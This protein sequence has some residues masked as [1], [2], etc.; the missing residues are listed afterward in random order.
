[1]GNS[2]LLEFK[3]RQLQVEH[4]MHQVWSP[5]PG[6][7]PVSYALFYAFIQY[8]FLQCGRKFGKTEFE[9][10]CMYMWAQLFPGS[11]IYYIADTMKHAGELVWQNGRL[12]RFFLTLKQMQDES[13][14]DYR[15][16][17]LIGQTLHTSWIE[18]ANNSEMRVWFRNGSFIKCDGAEN[19]ANADGIEPSMMVY[20]EYKHHDPRFHEAME[21]NLKVKKA[22][23]LIVGT[24]PE[25]FENNYCK[26]AKSFQMQ[27]NGLFIKR[28][29][30]MN[31]IM[32]PKGEDDPEFIDEKEKYEMRGDWDV[33]QRE[34]MAE[35]VLGGSSSIFPMF[36]PARRND[37]TDEIEK[38]SKHVIHRAEILAQIKRYPKDW[39]YHI[40]FDAGTTTC[41]AVLVGCINVHTKKVLILDEIYETNQNQTSAKQIW[42]RAKALMEKYWPVEDEWNMV[43]DNAAAWFANEILSEYGV[44]LT[45]C[46]KDLKNKEPRLSTI[47]DML[48]T[49]GR[50]FEISEDA[51]KLSWEMTNYHKDKNGKIPKTDDHNIDN[52]RYLLNS[53]Y[54]DSVP[55]F[56][57]YEHNYED[58]DD[59]FARLR[60]DKVD[61]GDLSTLYSED[62]YD[63]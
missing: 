9:I 62:Y 26:T 49:N 10:Y 13:E 32:Y 51:P 44:T 27:K 20:D 52:L 41:F 30:Y 25:N 15:S 29:S 55:N 14:A 63:D 53:M 2:P 4:E 12:P 7:A 36:V 6:Q 54:Y 19:Y 59:R 22:P 24:P 61:S 5:H 58:N 28:P 31:P 21:P 47:K 35:I 40:S 45:P 16:R 60:A 37:F 18:K 23:I 43:Y 57:E 39:E 48:L 56:E 46:T 3:K 17:C 33:F 11:Q 38:Y 34:Y 42:P 1:M 50:A 8:I